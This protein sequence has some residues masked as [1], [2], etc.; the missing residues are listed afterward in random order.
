MM[1]QCF[2]VVFAYTVLFVDQGPSA[3]QKE[4]VV[5]LEC[6]L[7]I[8]NLVIKTGERPKGN[9]ELVN[10]SKDNLILRYKSHVFQYLNIKVLDEAGATV[11]AG[12]YGHLF[13]PAGAFDMEFERILK[14]GESYEF[15]VAPFAKTKFAKTAPPGIY[16]CTAVYEY[17]KQQTSSKE[18]TLTVVE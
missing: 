14:P 17:E 12:H 2:T 1:K 16:R 3:A 5:K 8:K 10:I 11:S 18:V 13:A 7:R 4:K 9:V 15:T 6:R